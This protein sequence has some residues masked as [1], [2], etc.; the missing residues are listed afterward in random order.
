M[1]STLFRDVT[2][3]RLLVCY[4]KVSRRLIGP[5]F[6][7]QRI[8]WPLKMATICRA[9]TSL[10]NHQSTPCKIS[11][12]ADNL[13]EARTLF[14]PIQK[15]SL[16]V[17]TIRWMGDKCQEMAVREISYRGNN[18]PWHQLKAPT[19]SRKQA[20][21]KHMRSIIMVFQPP[22]TLRHTYSDNYTD[23]KSL[24]QE[25]PQPHTHIPDAW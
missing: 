23:C 18:R 16:S 2:Q 9:E 3:R 25:I 15:T 7:D 10:T 24:E 22:S 12:S 1:R 14:G 20:M 19:N 17:S 13:R 8:A 11:A 5:N 21:T 6:K 4:S